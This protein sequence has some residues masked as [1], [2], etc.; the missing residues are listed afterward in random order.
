MTV[1]APKTR[2]D[3]SVPDDVPL[4]DLLPGLLQHVGE[5]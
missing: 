4:A 5:D 1:V 3:L 2:V